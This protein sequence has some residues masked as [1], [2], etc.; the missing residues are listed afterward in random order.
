MSGDGN[1][2]D[3]GDL[4]FDAFDASALAFTGSFNLD[5]EPS[6][7]D[8]GSQLSLHAAQF[9]TLPSHGN[10]SVDLDAMVFAGFQGGT[11]VGAQSEVW[12]GPHDPSTNASFISFAPQTGPL[13]HGATVQSTS[14]QQRPTHGRFA[15]R[16]GVRKSSKAVPSSASEATVH[17][18]S[19]RRRAEDAIKRFLPTRSFADLEDYKTKTGGE[20]LSYA[21]KSLY[22]ECW[23]TDKAVV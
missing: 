21:I 17:R 10:V 8:T 22:K 13:T 18:D 1:V 19:V 16:A 23:E 5:G 15:K 14:S 11:D 6:Y 9:S 20:S 7:A 12:S 2:D 3:F 4:G